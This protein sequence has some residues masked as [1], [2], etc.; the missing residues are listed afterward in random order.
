MNLPT[1]AIYSAGSSIFID[2][3]NNA[4]T[5]NSIQDYYNASTASNGIF[6]ASNCSG[7]TIS[8]NKLFQS[9]TRT[10]TAANIHRGINIVTALGV[11]YTV[12]NNIIGYANASQTGTSTYTCGASMSNRYFGIELTVGTSAVSNV[13]GN[14][15]AGISLTNT[16]GTAVTAA[17]GIFTGISILAGS[18]NVGETTEGTFGN[19]IGA[20]T[21]NGSIT[22]TGSV[23][24]N[25]IAGIYVTSA[26]TVNIQN[27]NIGAFRTA[28]GNTIGYTFHAINTAGTGGFNISSNNIGSAGT[29]NSISVGTVSTTSGVCTLNGIY[30]LA[31]G[32]VS[33][34]GNTV[35][36]VTVYG[37]GAS[38]LIGV[39]NSTGSGNELAIT[40]NSII[41]IN[42]TGS[43][44][45]TGISNTA[46]IAATANIT[47][48]TIRSSTLSGT[49][50]FTGIVNSSIAATIN[51]NNNIIRN[52]TRTP[53][54]GAFTGI[55]STGAVPTALNINDNQLGNADGGLVT[56]SAAS[57]GA[58]TGINVSGA[59]ATCDVSI[60]RNDFSGIVHSSVA[61][62]PHTYIINAAVS[63]SMT[64][65]SNTFTNLNVNTTGAI[66]FISNN[67]SLLSG[68]TKNINNNSIVNGFTRTSTAA[69]GTL[70]LYTNTTGV[71]APGSTI[72]NNN[73]DF[74]NITVSG[75]AIIAG[76]INTD[77]GYGTKNLKNNTFSNWTGA[78]TPTG[79]FTGIAVN[80]IGTDN[81]VSGNQINTFYAGG[82]IYGIT[83]AAG[84]DRISSN[85]IHTLVSISATAAAVVNGIAITA[86]TLKQVFQNTIYNLES[87]GGFTTGSISGIAVTGGLTNLVYR[88]K[89]Y[90]ISSANSA[91]TTGTV[92]GIMVSGTGA[93]QVTTVRN[94][95][96]GDIRATAASAADPM[97]G[98][99]IANTGLRSATNV[100][101]NTVYLN[102]GQSTGTN[103]GSSGIYHAASATATTGR[104]DL[105]NNVIVNISQPK[106]TGLTVAFRRSAGTANTQNNFAV[107]SNNNLYYA[108]TPGA[109][110]LIY[111]DLTAPGTFQ[112]LTAY[113]AA[114]FTAGTISPRDQASITEN[115][116]FVSTT[117]GDA[118]Y[119]HINTA[120]ATQIESGAAN[121]AGISVDFDGD[122][123][124]GNT[125]YSGSGTMPDIGADEGNFTK[126]DLVGPTIS[127]T[128]IAN[129]SC[130]GNPTLSVVITDASGINTTTG[131]K[132][133]IYFKKSTSNN[134]INGNTSS[135]NGWK[136]TEAT[137]TASPFNFEINFSILLGGSANTGDI[138]QYFV[139]AQDLAATPNVSMN[140]G[141]FTT[142]PGSVALIT[143]NVPTA[144]TPA[145][146]TILAGLSG[147]VTIGSAG[148]YTSLTGA[149]GLFSDINIKG[150][151]GNLTATI[152]DGSVTET[153]A[154][155]LNTVRYGCNNNY[156]IIVNPNAATA[157]TLT[158]SVAGPL[159]NLNGAGN[160]TID[161]LNTG[162]ASLTISNTNSTGTASTIQFIAD[163]SNN[164]I[165]N[166]IIE[167]SGTGAA[168]GTILFS[169]GTITGNDANTI[170]YNTIRPAGSNLP[171]NAIYS[172]GTSIVADNSGNSIINNSIQDYFNAAAASNGIFIAS[173]SSAW[174]INGNKFFQTGDRTATAGATH[175]AINIV[176]ASGTG[177]TVNNNI[178]GFADASS[179]GTTSYGGTFANLFRA[180]EM[181][182]NIIGT[183]SVADGNTIGGINFT[184][185]S[186]TSTLP[187]IFSGISVLAGNVNIG[188]VTGNTIGS[189][190]GTGSI[191]VTSSTSLGVVTG[192]YSTTLGTVSISKNN[193]GS[194]TAVGTGNVGYTFYGINSAGVLGNYNISSNTVGGATSNSISIGTGSA[195]AVTTLYGI[196]NL[197]TGVISIS[198]N[199]VQNATAN[200]TG[201][202]LLTGILNSAGSGTELNLTGNSVIA[203]NNTGTGAVTGISNTAATAAAANITGNTVRSSTFT[204]TGAF[205]GIL[206]GSTAATTNINTNIIRNISSGGPAVTVTGISSTGAI[207]TALNINSNQLG[208]SDGGFITFSAANSGAVTG[209][210]VATTAA[211]AALSIQSNNFSGIV[212]SSLGTSTHTYII[213]AAAT[214][215]QN[216]SYNTFTN[217]NVNTTGAII[218]IQNN[219]SL[220]N[221]GTQDINNNSIVTGFTRAS[222]AASGA[223]TIFTSSTSVSAAG[224][225]INNNGNN[226]SNITVSGA[227]SIAGWINTDAGNGTKNIKN[228]T[229]ST[230]TGANTPTGAFTGITVNTVGTDNEISGNQ[231]NTFI[232]GGNIYG[233]TTAAGN[234]RISLNTIH[235]LVSSSAT[236]AAVVNGIA[237]T[238]GTLKQVFQN[239]IYN[240]Q[241]NGGFTTG[242]I[243]GIAV[244][245]GLSSLIVR[246]R[247]YNI[248]SAGSAITTGTVNGIMVSGAVADQSTTIRNNIIGDI[249]AAAAAA[250]D[251]M[252]GINIANTGLRSSTN[253]YYNTVY[254]N[255]PASS[256]VNCG[257]SGLY[258]AANAIATTG[259]LDLRNNIILN[260]STPKGTGLTVAVR[261][262]A[263]ATNNYLL[264]SNNNLFYAGAPSSNQLVYYDGTNSA[265]ALT[266]Y[267][268]IVTPREI[269]SVYEDLISGTKFLSTDG[270]NANFLHLDP[271]KENLAESRAVNIDGITLDYDSD[272]RQ[273]NPGYTGFG[274]APDIG[275]DEFNGSP[276]LAL[277]GSYKVG[278]GERFTSF[279]N[280]GGL[281]ATINSLGLKGNVTVNVTSDL[282]EGGSRS[283]NQW[284]EEGA[285]NYTLTI[286]PSAAS[287]RI[288]SGNVDAG[289]IRYTGGDRVLIDGRFS[290][291]GS[292]LTFRNTSTV[293]GT[294]T[295]QFINDASDNTIKNC[296]IEGSGTGTTS[297]TVFLSAGTVTGND[298]ITITTNTIGPAGSNLPANAIYSAGSSVSIDNSEITVSDNLIKDYFSASASSNGIF[299][300]SNS[301]AWTI[302]GNKLFQ[303]ATRTVTA[304]NIHRGIN[305]VT[306]SGVGYTVNNNIV[307]FANAAS[308][309]T[310]TYT[311]GFATIFRGIEM[312]VGI[313]GTSGIQGNTIGGI[314]LATSSAA[315]LPGIFSGISVLSGNVNIGTS[316]ANTVGASTGTGSIVVNSTTTGGVV[317]GIYVTTIGSA[318]IRNNTVGSVTA[319]GDDAIGFTFHGIYSAGAFGNCNII[320]NTIGSAVTANSIS[321]GSNTAT[322]VNA[323]NGI[324]NAATGT[325]SINDNVVRNATVNGSAASVLYGILNSG[326]GGAL[327]I[328][329]NNI[330]SC[331]NMGTGTGAFTAIS[332]TAAPETA[333]INSN[334]IRNNLRTASGVFTGI[335]STGAIYS[336][337]NVDNNHLG[338]ADGGLLVNSAASSGAL[339]G[340][341]V[342][343]ATG[344]SALSIQGNDIRGITYSV[345]STSANTY[346]INTAATKSQNIS[347]NTFTDLDVNTSGNV[348]FIS[349]NVVL[350]VDG[351]QLIQNNR[352]A[353]AIMPVPAIFF[354]KGISGGT[355]TL[356]TSTTTATAAQGVTITHSNNNFSN[357]QVTG[358]TAIAGWV[359]TDAGEGSPTLALRNNTFENWQGG[360]GAITVINV[361]TTS[362][363]NATKENSIKKISSSGSITGIITGA[364]NDNIFSNTID[365]LISEGGVA[366]TIVSGI[367]ITSG[368]YQNIYSNIISHLTGNG[369]TTGT[370]R[371]MLISG[372]SLINV[373]QNTISGLTSNSN[374]TGAISGIW[375][376]GGSF[377]NV[378]RNKI[379]DISSGSSAMSGAG[380]VQ[381]IHVSGSS[382]N[383]NVTIS[384]NIIGDIRTLNANLA[385]PLRGISLISTGLNSNLNIYYN[386]VYLNATSTRTNF[387]TSG[388]HHVSSSTAAT[389]TLDLRNN[390]IINNSES[391]GTGL[392]V[393][394][395]RSAP[396]L[397][398]YALTSSN[399]LY[400]A[401]PT[402][403]PG[404]IYH[405]GTNSDQSLEAFQARVTPADAASVTEDIATNMGFLSLMGTA[406]DYLHINPAKP[407]LIE[408]GAGVIAGFAVDFDG[409][410]RNELAPDIGADESAG[411]RPVVIVSA[412]H[413][414][415]NGN[416]LSLGVAFDSINAQEQTG[417][418][419]VL[420][421]IAN[422]LEGTT[423]SLNPGSWNSLTVYPTA[424]GIY[425]YGNIDGASLVDLNGADHVTFDGRVNKTGSAKDL[426]L[427]NTYTGAAASTIRFFGS[428]ENNTVKYCTVK[429]AGTGQTGGV[430]F[431]STAL[432]GNG[433]NGN[434]IDHCDLTS[435]GSNRPYN[436]VYSSGTSGSENSANTI[437]NNNIF[438]FINAGA[439]S[440]GIYIGSNST[441][442]TITGNSFYETTSFTPNT[443]AEYD[444]IRID[445]TSGDSFTVSDNYIGG[446]SASC[447]GGAWTVTSA[448]YN[449]FSGIRMTVGNSPTS[450]VQNNTIQ[451]MNYTSDGFWYGIY[452]DAGSINIGTIAGNTIGATSG[453]SSIT[454]SKNYNYSSAYGIFVNGSG[455]VNIE[456]NNIGSIT[457]TG[458]ESYPLSFFGIFN[459]STGETGRIVGNL[460]GSIYTA[461]SIQATGSASSSGTPQYVSGIYCAA[462]GSTLI[463]GNT[464]V[465]MYNA[466]AKPTSEYGNIEGIVTTNGVNTILNNTIQ[467]LN[468]TSPG[469]GTDDAASVL[470]ISQTSTSPGQIVS[471]NEIY[472]LSNTYGSAINVSVIG[473]FYAGPASGTNTVSGNFIHGLS[474]S[475]GST[476][477]LIAGIKTGSGT[478]TYSNNIIS[479][480]GNTATTVY[481]IYETGE[482]NTNNNLYF[483]TVYIEGNLSS[484]ITDK[485]YALF[486]NTKSNVR[487]FRNNVL[488]NFRSTTNGSNLHYAAYFNYTGSG[489]LI[490][491]YNDYFAP[492]E[493]GVVGYYGGSSKTSL[494]IV[495]GTDGHST[496]SDP[497]FVYAGGP[498][499]S[500]Y[501]LNAPTEGTGTTGIWIDYGMVARG[502][503]PNIGAWELI[504]NR[505]IGT[506]SSDFGNYLNWTSETVPVAGAN[507]VF[508]IDAVNDCYLDID[509]TVG[510]I[511]NHTGKLFVVNEKQLTI[512]GNPYLSIEAKIDAT[513]ASSTVVFAGTKVQTIPAETF[514][515]NAVYNLTVNTDYGVTSLADLAVTNNLSLLST[516]PSANA[517][518]LD[519]RD[520]SALKIL[521]MGANATTTGIGDVTGIV[522][523]SSFDADTPYS[524]GNEF[525]T[526]T[527]SEGGT[528]PDDISVKISIGEAPPAKPDAILRNYD[529]VRTGGSNLEVSL[530]QHYLDSELNGIPEADLIVVSGQTGNLIVNELGKTADN[531]TDNWVSLSNLNIT[532]F[533]TAPGNKFWTLARAY[534]SVVISGN[535]GWRMISSPRATTCADLLFGF[536]SQGV[537]GSTYPAKQPNFLWFDETDTL[538]TNMSWR[539]ASSMNDAIK[540][541]RGYYFYVF[542][543]I[544]EDPDYNLP[545][546]AVMSAS[547]NQDFTSGEYSFSGPNQRV[548]FSPRAGGQSGTGS[549]YDTNLDDE[550]WNM[551]GNPSTLSLDWDHPTGWTKTNLDNAIYIWDPAANDWKTWNGT[552]GTLGT[553]KIAPFQAFW[554]KASATDPALDFTDAVLTTGGYFYGGG[555]PVKST[556]TPSQ[557]LTVN[558]SLKAMDM[559]TSAFLTFS[560]DAAIGHDPR[561]AFRLEPLS[562][563]WLELFS[564]ASPLHTEPLVINNLPPPDQDV[565]NLPLFT[566]GQVKGQPLN[567]AYTME[568]QLPADWPADW[569]ISLHDH[570]LKK[571]LSMNEQHQYDF[572]QG[573]TKQGALSQPGEDKQPVLPPS[574]V[575]PVSSQSS[576][577]AGGEPPPFSIIIERRSPGQTV[578]YIALKP[579]LLPNYP[580]PFN[581]STTIRFSLPA[582]GKVTLSLYNIYGQL[583]QVI[584]HQNF[585]A[586]MHELTWQRSSLKCGIYLLQMKTAENTEVIKLNIVN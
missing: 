169:T 193:I 400:Y 309:G 232:G 531:A 285:G 126:N 560:P 145:S 200:G 47:T 150:L 473:L 276:A 511:T 549:F 256:G 67:V 411:L 579:R 532:D 59:I 88:N 194:I 515:S 171:T 319:T 218:F 350:P 110:N 127:Y 513:A 148:T 104:L 354:N 422:S 477:G 83:T 458:N 133:R 237:I 220:P 146:F 206:N 498:E 76:W 307:G 257:S 506:V 496:I 582:P 5:G 433:N 353:T 157:V 467:N 539:T 315:A 546:P 216:I 20:T 266:D 142:P 249:R 121:I 160:V 541:G 468:T 306:P 260:Q 113:K 326:A 520:T 143:S 175:R 428:A 569:C 480:G 134:A 246:N 181:T 337:L 494:P 564:V 518:S 179:T 490:L 53:V 226:F 203:I 359:Q 308:T 233:I 316:T 393:A 204:G 528:M 61:T 183:A 421:V 158:G 508:D 388:I 436:I 48:N 45:I 567:G 207:P 522:K 279:T 454:V 459:S 451:N 87:N 530:A 325:V 583:I 363:S 122:T 552:T 413:A 416:Y 60:Q 378:D 331:T 487:N 156:T 580:N 81:E 305:I 225:T 86:G 401:G 280:A 229:F 492:G 360:S 584:D 321:V 72:N 500:H 284:T 198:D 536:T 364:G 571:A 566:G 292:Y 33:I 327:S 228:N 21:G 430:I 383:L 429:G 270:G 464:I 209:I 407:T 173:N 100:Y 31:T 432:S 99:N 185:S 335:S 125:G 435:D 136:Y 70:T 230:W 153:G 471:G 271:A 355:L 339:T 96:I 445:N 495:P 69:S 93:D 255:A 241:S 346:I 166:C 250:A 542:G 253:V 55:S 286:R 274:E 420:K 139:V 512:Q 534:S 523:R 369:P 22:V 161:G 311:G 493:G 297:G 561:D 485:S 558:L 434:M 41:A 227:A 37:T 424:E 224:S 19:T 272:I 329:G 118:T 107:T 484:G 95:I 328:N 251:P 36:N 151:S 462:T 243:S 167:G 219:V 25:Y 92:N 427:A 58:L 437:S 555:S 438:D 318:D 291:A 394:F 247:I 265:L 114:T 202:S 138:I 577:K 373:Y 469:T 381:G 499:A 155:A 15:I 9:A 195:A 576:L 4:I 223:L 205:T 289:M 106:G 18:V 135:D 66:I 128:P 91:I 211:T 537:T 90:N 94:N 426:T 187:G 442:W 443:F 524:F 165:T 501:R 89:I 457:T 57:S 10:A 222:T 40:G 213:N 384:N 163:A 29:A 386:T 217:L 186:G 545:L 312:T 120:T 101:F 290:G 140:A 63:Q 137:N 405:D 238:S 43:G 368:S 550:G 6:I 26:G 201:A 269:N 62:S 236:A 97:R 455:T 304:G 159:I 79:A 49:G 446:S 439:S 521:T 262:S 463:S 358:S 544:E 129:N 108:G 176:T 475:P 402:S 144:N 525:T 303:T 115:P 377:I 73:N 11:G 419:I 392:T 258:H 242:S 7:W 192:I 479:L 196:Y 197:A 347:N 259:A 551:V 302:T 538:T 288:I 491:D 349:N 275:A 264:T 164:T 149:G 382:A 84:N 39:Q 293:S 184:T 481:G 370:V 52:I 268:A 466:Y 168:Y 32:V 239:T 410:P 85:T 456:N 406:Q 380:S 376:S 517:G 516:N 470:G 263:S 28:G 399:N 130:T 301:A 287:P 191:T 23:T 141:A 35:Q 300:A 74:S 51:I 389:A 357:L 497:Q 131:T 199:A 573:S 563:T 221:G 170:S 453:N 574:I 483:N 543:A 64:I 50:A 540:S 562:D 244:T 112:T 366:A 489:N 152:I 294:S 215:S 278:L 16:I 404:L 533:L 503:P 408:S 338:N 298:N 482:Y 295:F 13:Q 98:I 42:N 46:A 397:A 3:S 395:R 330:I 452:L 343:G 248:S 8:G 570:G 568:W 519:M 56:F 365:S 440:N 334:I 71:S 425:I 547:G 30:N 488:A 553:G 281:F 2:N 154:N 441:G 448:N 234:D 78:N 371:G 507:I 352:L 396:D 385:N 65:S 557:P 254:M 147:N 465:N 374:T 54:T 103:C 554:V 283:L 27:N 460:I 474:L 267:Q 504:T 559:K 38:I 336:A 361:N 356:F 390:I 245:G 177:Y 317:T 450:S 409:E 82:N 527:F 44:A 310:T 415:S 273:G 344:S 486:S 572:S 180:I 449:T 314:Y 548:T 578:N 119:L 509:R 351:T 348:I 323:F 182:V 235:T 398:N 282:S 75:A 277:S 367:N 212:H 345:A 208:N 324:N 505:W 585:E 526:L 12:S 535:K 472:N 162:G 172:A 34:S 362:T 188:T 372:G 447:G 231:V 24:L 514:V 261:R 418:D 412:A 189:T 123:R 342:S 403:A 478:T 341:N 502:T 417:N 332:N 174:T 190:T 586:G 14:T 102:A 299:A 581:R 109:T 178:I 510:N 340:I 529:I 387:G 431:F 461:N 117:G 375:I 575:K 444:V 17:P 414:G 68:S 313:T 320:S 214:K 423:A 124:Q 132:P 105:R 210:T 80:T 111:Y 77:A 556:T 296:I 322:A 1:N 333:T 565:Y 476:S 116:D 391:F 252:R 240:L 379:Y